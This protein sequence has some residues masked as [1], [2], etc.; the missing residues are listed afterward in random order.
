MLDRGFVK[1]LARVR[2]LTEVLLSICIAGSLILR[3][4]VFRRW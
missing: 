1:H 3:T 4:G 2:S